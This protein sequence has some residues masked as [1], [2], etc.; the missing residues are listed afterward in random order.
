M[1]RTARRLAWVE[2]K[3]FGREPLT[4]VFTLLFPLIMLLVLAE[5]FGTQPQ[6]D[7]NG[8][9]VWRGVPPLDF[10]V[11]AYVALVA[12]AVGLISL[13]VHLA[14]YRE[15]GVLRRM[16]ASGISAATLLTA[17]VGVAIALAAGGGLLMG[18]AAA[19][20][21]RADAPDRLLPVVA[22]FVLV[23][24]CF[25]A[26]GVL[27]GALMPTARAAQG[28][29]L[30]LFFTMML[31]CGAGP[32]PEVLTGPLTVVAD[33]LPLTYAVRVIQDQWLG[34]GTGW[35]AIGVTA[36][37]LGACALLG[38]RLFRWE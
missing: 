9:P 36:G 35:G 30:P 10:Y 13:P 37:I 32:P 1:S 25:A 26:I 7:D 2:L 4:L 17:E 18:I 11:P 34:F 8:A 12:A 14:A 15:R 24:L 16:H 31:V 5:V 22:G 21:Y 27:L 19:A 3:L 6:V 33:A 38:L 29:G 20:V 28:A 23:T